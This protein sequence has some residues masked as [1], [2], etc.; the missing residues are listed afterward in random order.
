[1]PSK[2][3]LS[4]DNQQ[5]RLQSWWVVGFVDG[6]GCFSVSCNKNSTTKLGYQVFPEFVITQGY[7]S[8]RTLQRINKFFNCGKIYINRR[9][10]NHKENIYRYCVRSLDDIRG[11]IIPFFV[12]NRLQTEKA[13]DFQIFCQAIEIMKKKEHLTDKGLKRIFYLKST[14]NRKV[15]FTKE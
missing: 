4:A 12:K 5:E 7:K 2:K 1:M 8:L 15:K 10:D 11:V 14:M 6:E 3:D 9:H 13:R